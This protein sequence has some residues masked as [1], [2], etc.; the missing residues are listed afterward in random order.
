MEVVRMQKAENKIGKVKKSKYP[1]QKR[2]RSQMS[3]WALN[4]LVDKFN[5]LD[6]L[7]TTIHGHLLGKKTIT[8]SLVRKILIKFLIKI[9]LKI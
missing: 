7:K 4:T 2:H 8:F 6:K 1:Q 9:T 3:E 5:K